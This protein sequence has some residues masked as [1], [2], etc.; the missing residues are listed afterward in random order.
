MSSAM[1][2]TIPT[3]TITAGPLYATQVS[4]D[5]EIISNHT[6]TG[7]SNNDGYQ[8][9]SAGLN[10]ND[11]LSIQSNN[12]TSLRSVRFSNQS[13]VLAGIGDIGCAYEK[14][15]DLWYNNSAGIPIQIT[16]GGSILFNNIIN[17]SL[18]FI[19]VNHTINSS[20]IVTVIEA[21][22]TP[23]PIIVTLPTISNVPAGRFY[24]IKDF[25]GT[26]EIN[27]ITIN[28]AGTN[29]IDQLTT[30]LIEDNHAAIGVVSD[31]VNN[32]SLYQWNRKVY[33]DGELIKLTNGSSIIGD[34]SSN[35]NL[36]GYLTTGD[37]NVTGKLLTDLTFSKG[38]NIF[39][40]NSPAAFG[41][42]SS[43]SFNLQTGSVTNGASG[44][45]ILATG[46]SST[47]FSG[48]VTLL[49]GSSG[50]GNSG[51]ISLV[52]GNSTVGSSIFLNPGTGT[53]NGVGFFF[54]G[55]LSNYGGGSHVIFIGQDITDPSTNP[56][57]GIILYVDIFGNL[58]ARTSAGNIRTI[59]AV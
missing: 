40:M 48:S 18:L 11:D 14:S 17:Y 2:L 34:S 5:L 19:N 55:G 45:V 41:S 6:H 38:N 43:T 47:S 35:I 28:P 46:F 10:I 8:I 27:T 59:A 31:G 4:N 1:G 20:D 54:S 13:S 9:P 33:S 36:D 12:L 3:P 24:I 42:A 49:T 26:S 53:S 39:M 29:T 32:W 52:T 7:S 23:N 16:S 22:S 37:L 51:N 56:S 21:D 57:N 50:S 58:K 30:Y 15:G 44:S 25:Q